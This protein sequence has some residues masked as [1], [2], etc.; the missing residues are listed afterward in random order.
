MMKRL[1][2]S[3]SGHILRH[4]VRQT[5]T[6]LRLLEIFWTTT[7]LSGNKQLHDRAIIRNLFTTYKWLIR[8]FVSSRRFQSIQFAYDFND[9]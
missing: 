6:V 4:T 3:A 8:Q 5:A 7:K 1:L 2:W 9:V